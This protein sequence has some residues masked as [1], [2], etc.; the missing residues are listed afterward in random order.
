MIIED[1][2]LAARVVRRML[3]AGVPVE[4]IE[5]DWGGSVPGAESAKPRRPRR[6]R[7]G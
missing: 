4:L 2:E 5:A 1:D 3:D 6:A 7:M